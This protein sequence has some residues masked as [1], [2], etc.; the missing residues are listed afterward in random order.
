MVKR[1]KKCSLSEIIRFL[2][3]IRKLKKISAEQFEIG[4]ER[5]ILD[6]ISTNECK[7]R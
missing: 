7:F 4:Y 5:K 3:I 1:I 2:V 6:A